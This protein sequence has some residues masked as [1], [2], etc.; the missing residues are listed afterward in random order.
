M[1]HILLCQPVCQLE[2]LSSSSTYFVHIFPGYEPHPGWSWVRVLGQCVH[3]TRAGDTCQGQVLDGEGVGLV[4]HVEVEMVDRGV[5]TQGVKCNLQV[6]V[7]RQK[8]HFQ[9]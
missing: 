6:I 1:G 3:V 4:V 7:L 5:A 8:H 9:C 2:H